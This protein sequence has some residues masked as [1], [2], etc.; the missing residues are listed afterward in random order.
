MNNRCEQTTRTN[1][2]C[3]GNIFHLLS[4]EW[5]GLI[6]LALTHYANYAHFFCC[7]NRFILLWIAGGFQFKWYLII[8]CM[9]MIISNWNVICLRAHVHHLQNTHFVINKWWKYWLN[10]AKFEMEKLVAFRRSKKMIPCK[11]A[12]ARHSYSC[13]LLITL[14]ISFSSPISV[15]LAFFF[16]R[17]LFRSLCC[18]R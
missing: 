2:D 14:F 16:I 4:C 13:S 17:F 15:T 7:T 3:N 12:F 1:R 6:K 9:K 10:E 8:S 11:R 18:S 5:F